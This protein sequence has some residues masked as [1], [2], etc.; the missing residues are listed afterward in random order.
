MHI[1]A[2]AVGDSL[3]ALDGA[4]LAPGA[5]RAGY[6]AALPDDSPEALQA[7]EAAL[8]ASPGD[9]E[10]EALLGT[11]LFA[12]RDFRGAAEHLQTALTARPDETG[13]QL[14]AGLAAVGTS[15]TSKARA[16]LDRVVGGGG[17]SAFALA[18]L[19]QFDA[20]GGNYPLAAQEATR[21][22]VG[23]RP[24][25]E[26]P[27]PGALEGAVATLAQRAPPALAAPVFERAMAARPAWQ[28]GYWGSAVV[29]AR[30]GGPACRPAERSAVE[31]ERFGWTAEEILP[32]V[33]RCLAKDAA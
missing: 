24:T 29:G 8:H 26:R 28:T 16:L 12:R 30:A 7:A 10:R 27:F 18:V 11:I 22:I 23:L 13:W 19:A 20:N 5:S 32:L 21:S 25:L 2:S 6:A 31:L 3:P 17:D 15:D 33:Q 1:S 14:T 4:P 9:P